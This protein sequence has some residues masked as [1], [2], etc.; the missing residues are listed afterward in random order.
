MPRHGKRGDANDAA[1]NDLGGEVVCLT[2]GRIEHYAP[3]R[4]A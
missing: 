1:M 2:H 4:F 3:D